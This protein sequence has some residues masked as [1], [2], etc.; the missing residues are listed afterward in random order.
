MWDIKVQEINAENEEKKRV[1]NKMQ[2]KRM[3]IRSEK[4]RMKIREE[5]KRMK[6]SE[7]K[8]GWKINKKEK[9]KNS[10]VN[11]QKAGFWLRIHGRT[12]WQKSHRIKLKKKHKTDFHMFS[13][14]ANKMFFQVRQG[15][16]SILV[17]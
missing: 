9:R 13:M 6:I 8:K 11:G 15:R 14:K 10:P 1:G 12:S 5:K 16:Y 2:K 7:E 3:K 4:K 17:P